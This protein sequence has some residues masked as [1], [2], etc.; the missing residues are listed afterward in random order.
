MV[1]GDTHHEAARERDSHCDL[2]SMQGS[3]GRWQHEVDL[4]SVLVAFGHSVPVVSYT[5]LATCN[6]LLQ[7]RIQTLRLNI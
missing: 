2:K 1:E 4:L 3:R 7:N 5:T 6:P